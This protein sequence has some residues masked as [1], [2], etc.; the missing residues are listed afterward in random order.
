MASKAEE[1]AHEAAHHG[2]QNKKVALF[3]SFLALFL[4]ISETLAKSSQ[5][6]ALSYNVEAS[7]LWAFFQAKTIRMTAVRTAAETREF[8][9]PLIPDEAVRAAVRKQIE[10]WKQ[11]ANRY[12]T[13]PETQEGRR[14]LAARAKKSEKKR[15]QAMTKY[16]HFEISSAA[17]QIAI[18]LAS[19]SIV[20]NLMALVWV[21]AAAG[22]I[23][24][25]IM[26]FGQFAPNA[27]WFFG[28]H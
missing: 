26:G 4:A 20:A 1:A 15:D 13:E 19:A 18:V 6:D 21:S 24:L 9:L 22:G 14:E 2:V 7:N 27:L 10:T 23:G 12:D 28:G 8:D 16:H 17:F 25:A 3:I 5:T 11:I